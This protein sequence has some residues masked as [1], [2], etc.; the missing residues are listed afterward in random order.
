MIPLRS[1]DARAD[2]AAGL[3]PGWPGPEDANGTDENKNLTPAQ[4]AAGRTGDA[5]GYRYPSRALD[6]PSMARD[7]SEA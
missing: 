1:D 3:P 5:V 6:R 7:P 4:I 2:A